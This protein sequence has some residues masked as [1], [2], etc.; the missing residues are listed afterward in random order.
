MQDKTILLD[1]IQKRK[2]KLTTLK[3]KLKKKFIGIDE[4][5]DQVISSLST[6]Y[7][8]PE[9]ID[10]PVIINLWGMTGV[11]KTEMVTEI[12]RH[13]GFNDKFV[14]I[15]LSKD[16][17]SA[18]TF[19]SLSY[20]LQNSVII[21][22]TSSGIVL[23]DEFQN[24]ATLSPTGGSTTNRYNDIWDFLNNGYIK[25]L[26]GC[27]NLR[28][29]SGNIKK[30]IASPH[31]KTLGQIKVDIAD[32]FLEYNQIMRIHDF[33]IPEGC[34][35]D[36]EVE[37]IHLT[38]EF[39]K[40]FDKVLNELGRIRRYVKNLSQYRHIYDVPC[41]EIYKSLLDLSRDKIEY[42]PQY[43]P[44]MLIFIAGNL[45]EIYDGAKDVADCDKDPDILY[46]MSKA[47]T[48]VDIK[49]ALSDLFKPEQISRL[50]NNHVIFPVL[51]KK[52][53]EKIISNQI[54]KRIKS[55]SQ[56]YGIQVSVDKSIN[57]I[58]YQNGVFPSQ[59]V[60][61]ILSSL[62]II[63]ETSIP[64]IVLSALSHDCHE[65]AIS[66]NPDTKSLIIEDT[67]NNILHKMQLNCFVDEARK[68]IN[69]D[70]LTL[71][72]V[73]EAG[74]A[75]CH[76]ILFKQAPVQIIS[77]NI[78]L[79]PSGV[80]H[81]AKSIRYTSSNIKDVITV[82]LGGRVA[83]EFVFGAGEATQG[84]EMDIYNATKLAS[85][86][87]KRW[88]MGDSLCR[89]QGLSENNTPYGVYDNYESN[90]KIEKMVNSSLEK[91][92]EILSQNAD[93]LKDIS[94]H[95]IEYKRMNGDEFAKVLKNHGI[96]V[97]VPSINNHITKDYSNMWDK[98]KKRENKLIKTKDKRSSSTTSRRK[99]ACSKDKKLSIKMS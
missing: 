56:E 8:V 42:T 97:T 5:I 49:M 78:A 93:I 46:E 1:E 81:I 47:I 7:L 88:G 84:A 30:E 75:L 22:P 53:Y 85:N 57:N 79:G 6:W 24:Y 25:D 82:F 38:D 74:H 61:P 2:K 51:R 92:K 63:F 55:L 90:D 70:S 80:C 83:E 40:W 35:K 9:V 64:E 18:D 44:K 48:I 12:V 96:I 87:H 20:I 58:I 34:K 50:G 68:A 62:S 99:A 27:N 71:T 39:M 37:G 59:G 28:R 13:L 77:N 52:H 91:A 65:V 76:A 72:S 66:Y 60:R 19:A 69:I 43:F 16:M 95:L 17:G 26:E 11:G 23:L 67:N 54:K 94:D 86:F 14:S 36:I 89:I 45:D 21:K 3:R 29:I 31:F 41:S 33:Q 73:H 4:S 15:S 10:R 32:D 98:F